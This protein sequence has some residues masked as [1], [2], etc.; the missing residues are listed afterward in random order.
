MACRIGAVVALLHMCLPVLSEKKNLTN[1]LIVMV[2]LIK[3]MSRA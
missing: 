3:E 2:T 1:Q